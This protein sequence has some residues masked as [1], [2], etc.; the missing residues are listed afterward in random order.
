MKTKKC[1]KCG[2]VKE[3]VECF[4]KHGISK[5][6]G[7]QIYRANCKECQKLITRAAYYRNHEE[8]KRVA[9][10]KM[11]KHAHKHADKRREYE[12]AR[13]AADPEAARRRDRERYKKDPSKKIKSALRWCK[14]NPERKRSIQERRRARKANAVGDC[15]H[16]KWLNRLM[17]YGGKCVYCGTSDKIT[18]EH[19]I[20][21]SRGG[22]NWPSN[23]VPACHSCNCRKNTKTETEFKLLLSQE[24]AE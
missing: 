21:L 19:R 22:T 9:R 8:S 5:H 20:P 14:N 13:R 17:Y 18:M 4:N 23:I 2:E 15:S 16:E 1:S 3:K 10:E 7:E 6:T 24:H 11:A 12:A